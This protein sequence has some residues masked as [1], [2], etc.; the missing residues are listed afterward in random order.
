[1]DLTKISRNI[2]IVIIS[3]CFLFTFSFMAACSGTGTTELIETT[4]E[5]TTKVIEE[6][7]EEE[8]NEP[9]VE[10]EETTEEEAPPE[11]EADE[12]KIGEEIMGYDSSTGDLLG[13]LIIHSAD[14]WT[15]FEEGCEPDKGNRYIIFDIEITNLYEE[16]IEYSASNYVL[17]D[18]DGNTYKELE[19]TKKPAIDNGNF[20]PDQ[21]LRFWR[22]IE[23]PQEI[24][25]TAIEAKPFFTDTVHIVLDSPLAP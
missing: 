1:M 9:E 6:T 3:L 17:I 15:D 4:G 14:H 7:V 18:T 11:E 12:Y 25:I 23:V 24:T 19:C 2:I 5:E 8:V 20:L 16:N 21:S 10:V 13:S 22:T